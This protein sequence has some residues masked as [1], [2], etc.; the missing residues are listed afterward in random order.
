MSEN[1]YDDERKWLFNYV[2]NVN[3]CVTVLFSAD[4]YKIRYISD[5]VEE[6]LGYTKEELTKDIHF[7][8]HIA[9]STTRQ[10]EIPDD[11]FEHIE[12]GSASA[13]EEL[14][15]VNPKTGET[16]YFLATAR[17]DKLGDS[18]YFMI[19]WVDKTR[20]IL[21]KKQMEEMIEVANAANR[22]KTSFLAN[23]SHDFRTPMNAITNF[24]LLIAKNSDNPQ[25]VREYT[26]KIGL[27]CQNLLSLL[28]DVLDMSKIESGKTQISS[29]EFALG[30][31]LEEVNSVIAFQAKGKQQ[32]YQVHSGG[33]QQDLFLGDKKRINEILV[34]ILGNAVKYT[35]AGGKILFKITEEKA[36]TGDMC[37]VRFEVKDN[38]I[39]MSDKFKAQIFDAFTRDDKVVAE[40]IQG[41]G[42]GMAIT[43]NLVQ[44][45]GG[46]ISVDSKEGEGS[47][48]VITLRLQGVN[49]SQRDFW[50]EHGIK[51]ILVI[52]DDLNE[53]NKIETAL[54]DTGVQVFFST[55]G[56][57]AMHL[58]EVS[59]GDDQGFNVILLGMKIRSISC[60]DLARRIRDKK[61]KTKPILLLLT[62]EWEE[63]ADEARES[64][65]YD[66]LTKPF[67]LSTFR[68]LMEDIVSRNAQGDPKK[69]EYPIEGMRFLAAEDNEI[70]ADILT[71]LMHME[72]AEVVR[73]SDG[74]MA[75]DMFNESKPGEYDMILMDIQ[76]PVMDGYQATAMIRKLEREDAAK[77][78]IIAMTANA[79]ADDVQKSLDVGMNAHV[80]KPIN[81]GVLKS[82]IVEIRENLRST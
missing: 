73:A 3:Q 15:M 47:T 72:K 41:S 81:I 54:H 19:V 31:L 28:N 27:A 29:E 22:A 16:K 1:I 43:S 37:D 78:P 70:N 79:Y 71:E 60:F 49:R 9:K 52:D 39:G 76:M 69:N 75:V 26:H 67:F 14:S 23:M 30:L 7:F 62:D 46:T 58:I 33:M 55:S 10:D 2:V 50:I 20:E 44:M 13:P 8:L 77:I 38:G 32:D 82:T 40:G 66:F 12:P 11:F 4:D 57:K 21:Q 36:G 5:N 74:K 48:F 64:G 61:L 17:R 65:I 68:Q 45:M 18:E 63:I 25:R 59:D 53:C 80:A 51:R 24:N 34:N 42:L 35:P 6:I 56:Y